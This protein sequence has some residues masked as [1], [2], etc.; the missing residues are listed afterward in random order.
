LAGN[1]EIHVKSS[2]W[3]QHK[4]SNDPAYKNVILH[5]VY[6]HDCPVE[7]SDGNTIP[8]VL[9]DFSK[10]LFTRYHELIENPHPIHCHGKTDKAEPFRIKT[11]LT[12]LTVEKLHQ[13][14]MIIADMLKTNKNNWEET[15][16]QLLARNFGFHVNSVPFEML[17]RSLPLRIL[18]K[19][20]NSLLQTE[21]LLYGQS[22]L[23]G[24]SEQPSEYEK[25]LLTEYQFLQNKYSLT[26]LKDGIWKFSP[27][28]PHNFPTIRIS[29]MAAILT[30]TFPLFA[31]VINARSTKEIEEFF[32]HSASDFWDD[33]YSF[34]A[35]SKNY[36]KNFGKVSFNNLVMNTV[37]PFLFLYGH[38]KDEDSFTTRS[39]ELLESIPPEQNSII[40]TWK[41]SGMKAMDASESQA[42]L[43]LYKNFCQPHRCIE[44]TIGSMIVIQN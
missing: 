41:K 2:D 30:R 18:S 29:Q 1:V 20:K 38:I 37:A 25:Q 15:F 22:G 40:T 14:A 8:V 9:L 44:C 19:H 11:F 12:S 31:A 7:D 10:K 17:A 3:I 35:S 24:K 42:L 5:V 33:H 6:E 34:V 32:N 43:Y 27:V 16:Y 28:R 21:A 4:H 13:K 23:I 36:Q 39:V 26:P